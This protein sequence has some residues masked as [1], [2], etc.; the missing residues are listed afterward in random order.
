[1]SVA[2]T[3]CHVKT[4]RERLRNPSNA[5]KD[6]GIDLK[7]EKFQLVPIIQVEPVVEVVPPPVEVIEPAPSMD[8]APQER[9]APSIEAIQRAVCMHYQVSMMNL[10]SHRRDQANVYPRHVAMYL[11]KSLTPQTLPQIGRRFGGRDHTTI[12]HGCRKIETLRHTDEKLA[13][14]LSVLEALF[15]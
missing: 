10:L 6:M 12:L 15:V 7:R 14:E 3:L 4:V 13:S 11:A 1:M 2:S 9:P 5:V 8:E